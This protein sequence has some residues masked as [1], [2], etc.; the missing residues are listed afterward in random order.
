MPPLPIRSVRA[1]ALELPLERP[2]SSSLGSYTH[3]D[4]VVVLLH[5]EDGPT[6]FG[7]N[8]GLGGA[9]STALVPYIDSEL[10]PLA[11]GQDSLAP[12]ALWARLWGPNKARMRGGLGA[13]ALSAIDIACWDVVAKVAGLPLHRL[14]GGHRDHVPVYGSGGWLNLSD[15]ELVAEAEGFASRGITAYKFK[16]G[17]ERDRHRIAL[18]R[19]ALGPEFVLL[20]DANQRYDVRESIAVSRMLADLDV[21]WLEEPVY[22]DTVDDLA[23]VAAASAVPVAA[24]ENAYFRWGFREICERRAASFLQPDVGRC[25]GVTEFQKVAHLADAHHL[26]LTSHLW[27]ELSISLIGASPSGFMAEYA[28][29]MPRD[30]LTHPFEVTDG[31]IRVPDVAGHG[32]E[33]TPEAIEHFA[34]AG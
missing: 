2:I 23:E 34:A 30:A 32:V 27:H 9:A 13:W 28:E 12:E 22:A 33:F 11:V 6:G 18:L 3:V 19:K 15:D 16:I 20:A 10:G 7:F 17:G 21:A 24:G 8:A 4:C 25:G 5:T 29:L 1:I 26:S 14:L 31:G